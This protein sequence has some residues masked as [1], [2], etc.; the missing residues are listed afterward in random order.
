MNAI[1]HFHQTI[2]D[3]AIKN[4]AIIVFT[5]ECHFMAQGNDAATLK[6]IMTDTYPNKSS[7]SDRFKYI[8]LTKN[9][10]EFN[11]QCVKHKI[12]VIHIAAFPRFQ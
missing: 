9:A 5:T 4:N 12:N 7:V 6:A 8:V 3:I 1:D 11:R 2:K 10:E